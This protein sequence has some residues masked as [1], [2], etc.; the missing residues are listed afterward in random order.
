MN[1]AIF[2]ERMTHSTGSR[3]NGIP[4]FALLK[5]HTIVG[6]CHMRGDEDEIY[7]AICIEQELELLARRGKRESNKENRVP[8]GLSIYPHPN[9]SCNEAWVPRMS[10]FTAISIGSEGW[11]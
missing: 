5:P 7:S 10:K 3:G 4:L 8:A 11:F 1:V 6:E 9:G 2:V